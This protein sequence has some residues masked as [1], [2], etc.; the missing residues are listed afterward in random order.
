MRDGNGDGNGNGGFGWTGFAL[1]PEEAPPAQVKIEKAPPP[2][3]EG[4][5]VALMD[6]GQVGAVVS[7][8]M[9]VEGPPVITFV[10]NTPVEV[11]DA[12]AHLLEGDAPALPIRTAVVAVT[13]PH[14]PNI[15]MVV[16]GIEFRDVGLFIMPF[17]V[18]RAI[19]M[20]LEDEL[21]QA[22][23]AEPVFAMAGNDGHFVAIA[24]P[25]DI[26]VEILDAVEQ[27]LERYKAG[28]GWD[29]EEFDAAVDGFDSLLT[30][31]DVTTVPELAEVAARI[32]GESAS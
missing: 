20:D 19:S 11:I 3:A 25:G 4:M 31:L 13:V 24:F 30:M 32:R 26:Q 1:P 8:P 22:F 17:D 18:G 14:A 6:T 9:I 27:Q 12:I 2:S 23:E 16:V 29:A 7:G 10:L 5:A 21:L 28:P 15:F